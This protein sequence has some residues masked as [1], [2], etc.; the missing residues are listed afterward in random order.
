MTCTQSIAGNDLKIEL[1]DS[2]T[3]GFDVVKDIEFSVVLQY[4]KVDTA[5][6]AQPFAPTYIKA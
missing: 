5:D 2:T 1:S 6:N 4:V 3:S